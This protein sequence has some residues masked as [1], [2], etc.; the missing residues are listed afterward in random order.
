M[1]RRKR[2]SEMHTKGAVLE[3]KQEK[4]N[5]VCTFKGKVSVSGLLK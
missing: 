4:E 2:V 5:L 3:K 1:Q